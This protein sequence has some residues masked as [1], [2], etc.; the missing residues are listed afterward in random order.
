MTLMEAV[1]T[2]RPFKRTGDKNPG[3][4][5]VVERFGRTMIV[6]QGNA[7]Y[8]RYTRHY[9]REQDINA[10]DFVIQELIIPKWMEEL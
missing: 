7:T 10:N 2:G 4:Y 6:M 1:K 8:T 9:E 3:W 5:M